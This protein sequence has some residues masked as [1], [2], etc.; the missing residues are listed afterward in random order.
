MLK[1]IVVLLVILICFSSLNVL[2]CSLRVVFLVVFR[3]WGIFSSCSCI[4]LLGLSRLF[5]VMWK[6]RV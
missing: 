5:V 6:R 4:F 3:F 1:F 2:F